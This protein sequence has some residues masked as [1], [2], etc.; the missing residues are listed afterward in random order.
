MGYNNKFCK[1]GESKSPFANLEKAKSVKTGE[2]INEKLPVR[3]G[4]DSS[5]DYNFNQFCKKNPD[6]PMC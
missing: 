3:K 2:L 4:T 1:Y 5:N 6:H